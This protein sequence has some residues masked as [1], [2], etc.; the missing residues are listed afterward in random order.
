MIKKIYTAVFILAL[1]I[2]MQGAYGQENV[3]VPDY[4]SKK[5][6]KFCESVPREEIYVH[7]DREEYIAG[8]DIWF[9][10]YLID[11]QSYKPAMSSRIAYF[12]LL[13]SENRPVV[14][15][16]IVLNNG[17]GKGQI[18]L[19]DTLSTGNYTLVAYTSWM[20]NF[21]PSNCFVKYLTV[22]NILS[23]KAVRGRL[24][25]DNNIRKRPL[26]NIT[27]ENNN[28]GIQLNVDNSGP[29]IL[30]IIVKADTKFR[31]ENLNTFYIFIQT[32]GNIN[33]ISLEKIVGDITRITIPKTVLIPG[34][35][36]VTIF[37]S[38]AE[39]VAERYIYTPDPESGFIKINT[40]GSTSRR[41]KLIIDIEPGIEVKAP[42]NLSRLSLSVAPLTDKQKSTDMI[43]YFV[44]GSE[45]GMTPYKTLK[46]R[47]ISDVPSDEIDSLLLNISSSWINWTAILSGDVPHFRYQKEKEDHFLNGKLIA[48]NPQTVISGENILL[49]IPG[50][51]AVFQ[52]AGTDKEGN[53]SFSILIDEGLKDLIIM[54][55]DIS[56]NQKLNIESSFSDKYPESRL[57]ADSAE[58]QIPLYISDWSVNNQVRK[59]YGITSHGG[60]TD[61]VFSPPRPL[62]FYGKP[63][64]GLILADYIKLPKMEEV[65]FELLPRVYM[66]KN[67]SGYEISIVDRIEDD[68]Y[69]LSPVLLLDGVIIKDASVIAGLDPEIVEK[70]DVVKEKYLVRDYSFPGIINVITK[71]GD[72]SSVPLPEYMIRLPYKVTEPVLSFVSPDYSSEKAKN[73]RVPD[74][75]NTLYWNPSVAP[76]KEG[77]IKV[78]FWT[79]DVVTDYEINIQGITS[80]GKAISAKKIVRVE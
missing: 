68:P 20:K 23:T 62:R 7:S 56:K 76:D 47:N 73:S 60:A 41:S 34:I 80:D 66:K 67:R 28:T 15:K 9:N 11:R 37:N 29:D 53:F 78:E 42:T 48:G 22:Y 71:A 55:D 32:H 38:K 5:F 2:S 69:A 54:P 61:P 79:S 59:I 31:S 1:F 4:L 70:I 14:Q 27:P 57:S 35:N 24:Q 10:I 50:K 58:R 6:V 77:K 44:F 46:G 8:E 36:Q 39:P 51:E 65:F 75:R 72:F 21:L 45:F 49:C 25:G 16:R 63:D 13:N 26:N 3:N 64:I 30:E 12:E 18:V 19:P 17:I 33:Y 43:D 52:C 74:F 40:A